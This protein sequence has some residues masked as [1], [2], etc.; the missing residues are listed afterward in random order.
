[1]HDSEDG[2]D[3]GEGLDKGLEGHARSGEVIVGA[4]DPLCGS[5]IVRWI[6]YI[7]DR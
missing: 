5:D 4:V 2:V 3:K 1:M 6:L 7:I